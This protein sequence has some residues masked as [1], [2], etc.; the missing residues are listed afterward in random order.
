MSR[1]TGVKGES[2]VTVCIGMA[3]SMA[4]WLLAAG[5]RG[6]RMA[7]ENAKI[8]VHQGRTIMGG[9]Y[10][11][12]K[13]NMEDFEATQ[14]QLIRPFSRH[15][16]KGENE[17]FKAI[18]RDYWMTAEDALKFGVIDKVVECRPMTG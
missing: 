18:D 3:A 16:G 7:S 4:A 17:L 8:M 6:S 2:S 11:D 15:T 13:V 14:K 12:L 5:A 10:S 1:D 9:T